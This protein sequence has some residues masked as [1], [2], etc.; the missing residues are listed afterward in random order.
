MGKYAFTGY[1]ALDPHFA[2]GLALDM[3]AMFKQHLQ[4]L[5]SSGA[6]RVRR[7]TVSPSCNNRQ[8]RSRQR[9]TTHHPLVSKTSPAFVCSDGLQLI[10]MVNTNALSGMDSAQP[11]WSLAAVAPQQV[12]VHHITFSFPWASN[13]EST[14][15]RQRK[16]APAPPACHQIVW[17]A[18]AHCHYMH[19]VCISY[20]SS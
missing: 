16:I 5:N 7:I 15:S 18:L 20:G 2:G 3:A 11:R 9:T 17:D 19:S 8:S 12:A 10:I 6:F 14:F 4:G 1:T 13:D